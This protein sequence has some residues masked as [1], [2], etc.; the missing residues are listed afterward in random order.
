MATNGRAME[1]RVH[2]RLR[3]RRVKSEWNEFGSVSSCASL[4]SSSEVRPTSVWNKKGC[5]NP[6]FLVA[7][8]YSL[9]APERDRGM[10][11]L[12]TE[13]NQEG[14][15][16]SMAA[17]PAHAA[18]HRWWPF[19]VASALYLVLSLLW[20]GHLGSLGR[21][22]PGIDD[23]HAQIWWL[24]WAA[25]SFPHVSKLFDARGMNYPAGANFGVNGSMLALGILFAPITKLFG[26]TVTFNVL[27]RLAPAVSACAMCFV[28]RRWTSWWPAA[29]VGG[30]LYGFSSYQVHAYDY[31]F[32]VFVPLPPVF[33]LL[34][35]EIL[36]RQK[37]SPRTSGLLLGLVCVLQFFI[38]PEALVGM[39]LVGAIAVL[40]YVLTNTRVMRERWRYI[41]D[42]GVYAIGLTALL[43]IYPV[44]FTLVGPQHIHGPPNMQF[45]A[46]AR[47]DLCG[48]ILPTAQKIVIR[49]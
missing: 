9:I 24:A 19:A 3:A 44:A 17:A 25:S 22:A 6:C 35:H 30:L 14:R 23:D 37:W 13:S 16:A 48:A 41:R 34:L 40:Y 33:F 45:I 47:P 26:V 28:L 11:E 18:K 36:V 38:F 31:V 20:W 15:A 1:R 46:F 49:S 32:L 43:L 5:P 8:R 7:F 12:R 10:T 4:T 27:L 21:T 2:R 42:A 29:F 39:A